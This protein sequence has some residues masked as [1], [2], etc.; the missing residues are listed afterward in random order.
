MSIFNTHCCCCSVAKLC[1]TLCDPMD[2]STP[3]SS[4]LR[5]LLEL[6]SNSCPWV[7]D[8]IQPSHPLSPPSPLAL[9]LSQHQGL[10]HGVGSSHQMAKVMELQLQQQDIQG[11]FPKGSTGLIYVHWELDIF[12]VSLPLVSLFLPPFLLLSLSLCPHAMQSLNKKRT[13]APV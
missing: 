11:R 6:C 8:A 7:G 10:F 13:R 4:V 9:S 2:C 3:G 5:S 12:F 1:P